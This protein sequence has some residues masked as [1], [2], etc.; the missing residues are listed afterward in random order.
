M[1]WRHPNG[2]V[3]GGAC[4][5]D[6]CDISVTAGSA[7]QLPNAFHLL[8]H[9]TVAVDA[10]RIELNFCRIRVELMKIDINLEY[11]LLPG[12]LDFH[13]TET[14]RGPLVFQGVPP[15]DHLLA[16]CAITGSTLTVGCRTREV[17]SLGIF[18]HSAVR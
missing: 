11:V 14:Q 1:V 12:G 9:G 16:H 13:F 6:P 4:G 18:A 8:P 10:V 17:V 7:C 3:A 5:G 15:I 2:I